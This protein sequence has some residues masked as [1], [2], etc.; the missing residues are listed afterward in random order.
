M[1]QTKQSSTAL[2]IARK[3]KNGRGQG[4]GK[5]YKPWL[6]I[7]D[8]PSS[9]RSHRVYSHKTE[10]IHHLLSDLEL[11]TFLVFESSP[12]ITNIQEQ[13]PLRREDTQELAIKYHLRHSAVRGVD[14]VMSSD[15]L[16]DTQI[17]SHKQFAVQVKPVEVLSNPKIVE[18]LELE[19]R[20]WQ[21]KK[22][23]WFLVTERQIDPVVKKNLLI[24]HQAGTIA[25]K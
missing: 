2:Q 22:I 11:A 14:Q 12:T 16:I 24:A 7:H 1:T 8:V 25:F 13:F 4:T 17:N 18:K 21:L 10:R 20:Y 19:R 3:V 15:F 6:H 5:N 23:P 9:G